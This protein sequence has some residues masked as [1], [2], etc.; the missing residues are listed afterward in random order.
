MNTRP[1]FTGHDG[2]FVSSR[3]AV[4]R[5]PMPRDVPTIAA[6]GVRGI[7]NA[8]S[9][10]QAQHVAYVHH[11]PRHIFWQQL[12]FWD[13]LREDGPGYLETLS[14]GYAELVVKMDS[15]H[16][17]RRRGTRVCGWKAGG[18]HRR[19]VES[20]TV[21]PHVRAGGLGCWRTRNRRRPRSR[22]RSWVGNLCQL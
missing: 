9:V 1:I 15:A 10:C 5:G 14:A 18:D 8:I 19:H 7:I 22:W 3:I 13:G 11:L 20:R 4:G 21:P 12:G 16:W 17:A 6:A 2:H